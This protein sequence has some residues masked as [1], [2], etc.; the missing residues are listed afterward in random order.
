M[1]ETVFALGL[2]RR[3]KGGGGTMRLRPVD[4]FIRRIGNGIAGM[5]AGVAAAMDGMTT[6]VG[7]AAMGGGISVSFSWIP[8]K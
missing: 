6:G 1:V 3:I 5:I 2:G 8:L 4:G 7:A